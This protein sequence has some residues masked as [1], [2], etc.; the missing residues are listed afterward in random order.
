M[1]AK[2]LPARVAVKVAA[3]QKGRVFVEK[4]VLAT[5]RDDG[6]WQP[7]KRPGW[8]FDQLLNWLMA[9]G[10][11]FDGLGPGAKPIYTGTVERVYLYRLVQ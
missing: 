2:K 4:K 5:K 7:F 11:V 9:R 1:S 10:Y 8:D 3:Y 6:E